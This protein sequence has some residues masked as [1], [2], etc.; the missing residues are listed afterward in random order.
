MKI[1]VFGATGNMG[2]RV[3]AAGV[4]KGHDVTAFVRNPEKLHE[5]QGERIAGQ[6]KVI[7]QDM[8]DPQCVYNAL[9]HQ[10]VAIIAAGNAGQGDEFNRIVDTIVT[11]CEDHP[12]FSGRVWVM[13]GAGLLEIPHTSIIGNDLPG[14]PPMFQT[15]NRNW[16]RLRQTK[17]DW[18]IMC[19]GTMVD[20]AE[21]SLSDRIQVTADILPLSFPETVGELSAAE[22]AGQLFG[23]I[24]ELDVAYEHVADFMLDHLDV[25]GPYKGKRVGIAYR[26]E[27]TA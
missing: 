17:L 3:L 27:M 23:R 7:A 22:L 25:S 10:D 4:T 2:K 15:H 21:E 14:F 11:Q 1:I 24:Q 20:E 9:S 13:G 8:L 5:Q 19:P 6:V 12:L 18:S 16:N 26:K